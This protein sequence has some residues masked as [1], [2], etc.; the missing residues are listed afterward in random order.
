MKKIH[1]SKFIHHKPLKS[2]FISTLVL[3]L[4]AACGKT[5]PVQT[6]L[7]DDPS[8]DI[9][10]YTVRQLVA[11]M[12]NEYDQLKSWNVPQQ[13]IDNTYDSDNNFSFLF[14]KRL[15]YYSTSDRSD[16][17]PNCDASITLK[18]GAPFQCL[19]SGGE[20]T[21]QINSSKDQYWTLFF[22]S[23]VDT[24][25]KTAQF[26]MSDMAVYE[27]NQWTKGF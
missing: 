22:N 17:P 15:M 20:M 5:Y 7:S 24:S 27:V 26:R 1:I 4:L 13:F 18:L 6:N 11:S 3:S 21:I 8:S 19:V 12:K 9:P 10:N 14:V 2:I 25:G 23:W 16:N